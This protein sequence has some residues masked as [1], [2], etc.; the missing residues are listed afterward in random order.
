MESKNC[1]SYNLFMRNQN[2]KRF[3]NKN[4]VC[5]GGGTGLSVMLKGFKEY[6]DSLTAIVT[7]A[8]DGGGSGTL[9]RELNILPP[10]DIRSCITALADSE[11]IM[12][13]LISYRFSEGGLKGQSFGNL[14][15]AAMTEVCGGDFLKAVKE[16][17]S[18]LKVK[19]TVLPVTGSNVNLA[20]LLENGTKVLGE[21]E[22]GRAFFC[23]ESKIQRVWLENKDGSQSE[24]KPLPE[25]VEAIKK[26][27]IIT[28]G[29]GSLYT[30]IIPNLVVPGIKEAIKASGA[31]VVFINNIMTQ[32]GE[33]DGYTAFDHYRAIVEHTKEDLADYCIINNGDA[34]RDILL[35]YIEDGASWV[36]PDRENFEETATEVIE[37][38]MI[39][40]TPNGTLRHKTSK[41]VDIIYDILKKREIN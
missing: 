3:K 18:V 17:S 40:L 22:I 33:T 30:S 19:G 5:I 36:I 29:P 4:I 35:K 9:R 7:V 1:L 37:D 20:A 21:S 13:E 24:I 25:T 14:L 26:A 16:V 28:L 12:E 41:I 34:E 10:G 6:T 11:P 32:P 38:D 8:D 27:D 31:P 15:L 23:H 2:S 39:Y